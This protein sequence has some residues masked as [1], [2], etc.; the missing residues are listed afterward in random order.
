MS[1]HFRLLTHWRE[2]RQ[3][4]PGGRW[5]DCFGVR[6]FDDQEA[7]EQAAERIDR[8]VT[9]YEIVRYV[10]EYDKRFRAGAIREEAIFGWSAEERQYYY[11]ERRISYGIY[12]KER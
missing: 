10:T 4:V 8:K 3:D 9:D 1:E 7:A 12:R 6:G 2:F 5:I 11:K